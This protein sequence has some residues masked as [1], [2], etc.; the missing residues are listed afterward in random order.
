[1]RGVCLFTFDAN[2]YTNLKSL[3]E[4]Q[5]DVFVTNQG[6]YAAVVRSAHKGV[7]A[8]VGSSYG[9]QGFS[10]RILNN[11]LNP[12]YRCK[13]SFKALHRAMDD[14]EAT[15]SFVCLLRYDR[16]V[17]NGQVLLAE[18][19]CASLV[20]T[21][22]SE[23][24]RNIRLEGLPYVRWEYGLNRSDP[25]RSL[26]TGPTTIGNDVTTY[27]RLRTLENCLSSGP[28]RV[29][30]HSRGRHTSNGFYQFGLSNENFTIPKDVA[31]SWKLGKESEI[32]VQ[33]QC[34]LDRHPHAFAPLAEEDDVGK[35]VGIKAFKLVDRVVHEH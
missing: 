11:H 13:Y 31:L 19:T 20:G 9:Q 4:S 30:F 1:M 26:P 14:S 6:V 2:S 12:I 17:P 7:Q 15:T 16:V 25:L 35:G 8:Y 22:D 33:W 34:T 5:K 18:A 10:N 28:I 27:R 32:N 29:G 3:S 21:F 23:F 24:Y